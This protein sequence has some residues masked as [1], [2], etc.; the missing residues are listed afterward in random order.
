MTPTSRHM[1][2]RFIACF[3]LLGLAILNSGQTYGQDDILLSQSDLNASVGEVKATARDLSAAFRDA[4]QRIMPSVVVVLAKRAD[5]NETLDQLQ[6]LDDS[7]SNFSAGSGVII[8]EDGWIVTNN[9][10][11]KDSSLV[12]VR[13]SDGR[14]FTGTDLKFD[15][16]SDL[17]T[18]KITT[19]DPLTAAV[20][21]DSSEM[22]VG[23][24][25]IAVG[26]PFLLE[27]TVSAGIISG[28]AR[29]LKGMVSG[30][31][32]QTDASINP[33]N[34]GG[35]LANL[36]GELIAINTAIASDSGTFQGVGFAIPTS[37]VKW[38]V[39][40]LQSRGMVRRATLGVTTV[41]IPQQVAMQL[42]LPIRGGGAYVVRV[43]YDSPAAKAGLQ[44]GDVIL[45]IAS[46]AVRSPNGLASIVEQSPIDE[47]QI[48]ELIRNQK[49][50]E[51]SVTLEAKD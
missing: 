17:A 26:S 5:V 41:E 12:R 2:T 40:E 11:V 21:G 49:R 24:W 4:A 23:D 50:M 46:Q 51:V 10:V 6:L 28:K 27:Q 25:V 47:P 15:P 34:S 14:E 42:N 38:I 19:P 30:Q 48:I 9:H 39:S 29:P 8:S 7:T 18:F 36:D 3:A 35:A 22:A 31:L 43:R 44:S 1:F 13:L 20:M 37:R 45:Q 16:A 33:G 32:L